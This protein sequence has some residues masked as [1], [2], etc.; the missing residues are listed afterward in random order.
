VR[1]TVISPAELDPGL[2]RRW[3]DLVHT[4]P[5]LGSPYFSPEFTLAVAS[6]RDDVRI[7]V[8]EDDGGVVGFF[9]FQRGPLGRGRPVG[10]PFSDQHGIVMPSGTDVDLREVLRAARLSSWH[11]DHGLAAQTAFAPYRTQSASSPIIDLSNGFDAY[12]EG[13][14]AAG[15]RR[16]EQTDRKTRKLEREVGTLRWVARSNDL[17][18]L[19]QII[20]AKSDQCR[21]ARIPDIFAPRWTRELVRRVVET[22]APGFSGHLS[23]LYAGDELVAAHAGMRTDRVWHWWFPTYRHELA[24]YSPG[25][26][27]LLQLARESAACGV[28]VIDLGK[29]DD[30]YKQSF[31][32]GAIALAEGHVTRTPVSTVVRSL[33]AH[34]EVRLRSSRFADPVRPALRLGNQWV[35]QRR[36]R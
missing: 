21:A 3:N 19:Q 18:V 13:R 27:L 15:S 10:G 7:V 25:A 31:A 33:Q 11:F 9:P 22:D 32:N 14:R 6:V 16:I 4:D 34:A 36:F 1:H 28:A 12:V 8:M 24:R 35:R 5:A 30:A 20:D 23:C 26:A 17:G 29:G 2:R